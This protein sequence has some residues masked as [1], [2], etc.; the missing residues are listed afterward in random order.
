MHNSKD[1]RRLYDAADFII[2]QLNFRKH[3]NSHVRGYLKV[4]DVTAPEAII[5]VARIGGLPTSPGLT[6]P[7]QAMRHRIAVLTEYFMKQDLIV[8]GCTSGDIGDDAVDAGA[9]LINHLIVS[10][11]TDG[12]RVFDDGTTDEAYSVMV[13]VVAGLLPRQK[14]YALRCTPGTTRFN[15][16][17]RFLMDTITRTE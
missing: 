5:L 3:L 8:K 14:V 10:F 1:V 16:R 11:V 2:G 15:P 4:V 12:Q 13:A 6:F 17:L 9:V 7:K